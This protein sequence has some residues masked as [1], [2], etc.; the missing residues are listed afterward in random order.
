MRLDECK[1]NRGPG[2]KAVHTELWSTAIRVGLESTSLIRS[3]GT[4]LN[5]DRAG[6]KSVC[7]HVHVFE[8]CERLIEM[9]A[10]C[11]YCDQVILL[12][13]ES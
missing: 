6:R 2:C 9:C 11:F 12:F 3:N 8:G 4:N 10:N 7:D 13:Q 5:I 1:G